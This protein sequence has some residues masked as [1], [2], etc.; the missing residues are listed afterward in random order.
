M[1]FHHTPP[2]MCLKTL[3]L[4]LLLCSPEQYPVL[5]KP[6]EMTLGTYHC[7][8]THP[9]PTT[10]LRPTV[11]HT[12]N[13]FTWLV[14][15]HLTFPCPNLNIQTSASHLLWSENGSAFHPAGKPTTCGAFL[16]PGPF[17]SSTTTDP[18]GSPTGCTFTYALKSH[19]L[20][21]LICIHP[22]A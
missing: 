20:T 18:S 1:V 15:R 14:N 4:F 16:V 8:W 2:W 7:Q 19:H 17:P 5:G 11:L 21:W 10:S 6:I 3:G 22:F 12:Y 9:H 13:S